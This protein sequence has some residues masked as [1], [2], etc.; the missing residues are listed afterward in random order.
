MIEQIRNPTNA[1][2][3]SS[4]GE[5]AELVSA[6]PVYDGVWGELAEGPGGSV[7]SSPPWIRVLRETYGFSPGAIVA[8]NREGRPLGGM[9]YC[10]VED[11]IMGKRVVTL[12]F[13]D[14]CDPI[15]MDDDLWGGAATILGED[16]CPVLIRC[17]RCQPPLEITGLD[18]RVS[19][20]ALW[21]GIDLRWNRE[22]LWCGIR[23]SARRAVE[24]ARRAG[25][26][27]SVETG[28]EAI[29]EF[30]RMHLGVRKHK[31]RLLAQPRSFFNNISR[32]FFET[33]RGFLLMARHGERAIAGVL[34]L[35]WGDTLYYKFNASDP[36]Y[37]DMRPNHLLI[38]EGI[39]RAKRMGLRRWDFG[40]SDP[41][42]PGLVRF[43]RHFG[44]FERKIRFLRHE[45][46][47][48][49]ASDRIGEFRE[50]LGTITDILTEPSVPDHVTERA[51]TLLYRY[52]A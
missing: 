48:G 44:S 20:T 28:S 47:D 7:F 41:D 4:F 1:P 10:R 12:P 43:K 32:F 45:P 38:W 26:S 15:G 13:S 30:F 50:V 19:R 36:D 49:S 17:L 33:G 46:G 39:L 16:G 14:Y 22:E 6:D 31:Y 9:P 3:D 25:V 42:Q 24:K 18:F 29:D 27:I 11:P 37:L 2:P 51:G 40:L 5:L 23:D 8:L 34:I 35:V 52:F 21:H